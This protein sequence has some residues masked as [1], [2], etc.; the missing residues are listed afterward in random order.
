MSKVEY[1]INGEKRN[2]I[3]NNHINRLIAIKRKKKED[4]IKN[5]L[6]AFLIT[7]AATKS[8]LTGNSVGDVVEATITEDTDE[9]VLDC[10]DKLFGEV[11]SK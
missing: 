10:M 8:V 5:K 2:S 11:K 7:A 4:K 1:K 9:Q 6:S 3:I